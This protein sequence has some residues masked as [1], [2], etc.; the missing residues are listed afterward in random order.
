MNKNELIDQL[1]KNGSLT[2]AT[3]EKALK[4]LLDVIAETLKVPGEKISLPGFGTFTVD[5]RAAREGRNVR[6]GE[7]IQIAA[8]RSPKFKPSSVLKA[9]VQ[10]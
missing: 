3:A 10:G 4:S 9:S 7:K 2:K 8:S 5:D 6:T 1:A